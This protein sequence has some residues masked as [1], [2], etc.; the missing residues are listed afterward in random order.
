M[1]EIDARR[2]PSLESLLK[3]KFF[4]DISQEQ[5]YE[6]EK[7][8]YLAN[9]KRIPIK[10]KFEFSMN[11]ILRPFNVLV[12]PFHEV[13]SLLIFR[14]IDGIR[15]RLEG[16]E[17]QLLAEGILSNNLRRILKYIKQQNEEGHNP[18]YREIQNAL[19]FSRPTCRKKIRMLI[20]YRYLNE[21]KIGRMKNL[22][23]RCFP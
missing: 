16:T 20:L 10:E 3:A 9:D 22:M 19:N 4:K 18:T 8:I 14:E 21:V 13:S 15:S 2:Y 23:I 5:I 6:M 11:K 7:H 1:N 12:I 17:I